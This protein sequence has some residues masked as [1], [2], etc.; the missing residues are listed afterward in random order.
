MKQKSFIKKLAK[1]LIKIRSLKHRYDDLCSRLPALEGYMVISGTDGKKYRLSNY[2]RAKET[3]LP[4]ST[5]AEIQLF[6]TQSLF[7]EEALQAEKRLKKRLMKELVKANK[8]LEKSSLV[9]VLREAKT[10]SLLCLE[11]KDTAQFVAFLNKLALESG[12]SLIEKQPGRL[13][14]IGL[15]KSDVNES[16]LIKL[17]YNDGEGLSFG[18]IFN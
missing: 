1:R 6:K 7:A 8:L 2:G 3:Y 10:G 9:K 4:L 18:L 15:N 13:Y 11:Q 12:L 16:I 14:A 17:S 5:L